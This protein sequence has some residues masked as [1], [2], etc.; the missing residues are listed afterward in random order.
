M[1]TGL[2]FCIVLFAALGCGSENQ[3]ACEAYQGFFRSLPC[4]AT[5]DSGIQCDAFADHPCALAPYFECLSTH[6]QCDGVSFIERP[7]ECA[8]LLNCGR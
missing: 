5:L 7:N 6:Q 3:D 2:T 4:A 1:K 8:S